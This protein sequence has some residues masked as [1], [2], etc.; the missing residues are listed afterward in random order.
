MEKK[1]EYKKPKLKIHGDI[2]KLTSGSMVGGIE[3]NT[4][5]TSIG[6]MG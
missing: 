3:S 1:L 6:P 4:Y 5:M 2:N